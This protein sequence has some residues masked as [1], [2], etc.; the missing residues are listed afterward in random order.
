[1]SGIA[2]LLTPGG[3]LQTRLLNAL[4]HCSIGRAI[5]GMTTHTPHLASVGDAQS[6]LAKEKSQGEEGAANCLLGVI[7]TA[8]FWAA[9]NS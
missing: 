5:Q 1:M 3:G 9:R 7:C 8:T 6:S 2:N 4:V